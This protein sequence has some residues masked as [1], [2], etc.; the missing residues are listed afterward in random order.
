M[1]MIL[2][3]LVIS[4]GLIAFTL[5]FSWLV[6]TLA[7]CRRIMQAKIS[8]STGIGWIYIYPIPSNYVVK[9]FQTTNKMV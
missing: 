1:M 5:I 6:K 9:S 4:Y 7:R 2:I 8:M 3:S